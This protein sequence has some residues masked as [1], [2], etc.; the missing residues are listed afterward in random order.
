MLYI[1]IWGILTLVVSI[2]PLVIYYTDRETYD[3]YYPWLSGTVIH[4]LSWFM[5]LI[6]FISIYW[7]GSL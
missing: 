4:I 5:I 1:V 6:L 2:I 3:E 7:Q